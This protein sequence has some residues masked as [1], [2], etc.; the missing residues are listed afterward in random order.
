M[1]GWATG[2]V[3]DFPFGFTERGEGR[4]QSAFKK[5]SVIGS[6]DTTG[7]RFA[8]RSRRRSH[9]GPRA[10]GEGHLAAMGGDVD[11]TDAMSDVCKP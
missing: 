5:Q 8:C 7:H 1:T 2:T 10:P 9:P 4:K 6:R 3:A 11:E